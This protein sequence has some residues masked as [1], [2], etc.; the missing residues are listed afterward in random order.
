MFR[1]FKAKTTNTVFVKMKVSFTL[2]AEEAEHIVAR[3]HREITSQREMSC[4]IRRF[5]KD[6]GAD[7]PD[8]AL[9]YDEK[10]REKLLTVARVTVQKYMPELYL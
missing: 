2:V 1:Y 9:D 4:V 6:N 3:Y 5:F 8:D 7:F 10:E